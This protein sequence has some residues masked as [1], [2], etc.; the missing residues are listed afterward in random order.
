[1]GIAASVVWSLA[2]FPHLER[3][4]FAL[5]STD[6]VE[7]FGRAVALM[8]TQASVVLLLPTLLMGATFPFAIAAYQRW[9][10]SVG[11]GVGSLYAVNTLGNIAGSL[12]VGFVAIPLLG[13]RNSAVALVSVNLFVAAAL[14]AQTSPAGIRR[15]SWPVGAAVL[16]AAIHFGLS[17]QLFYRSLLRNDADEIVYYA[18]GASDTVAVVQHARSGERTLVYADGRGAAGTWTLRYNLYFGHLPMVLH[19][20]PRRVLHI[21]FGAG[22]S[23]KALSRHDVDQIDVVELSP[24]VTE[25][26]KYFWSNEGVL[27]DPRV[28]LVIEDGRNFLLRSDAMYDVV[29]LEPPKVQAAGVVN[30]YTQEF[31]ELVLAHLAPGGI[32]LQWLPTWTFSAADRGHLLR[33]FTEVFPH[34]SAWQQLR[35]GSLLLLGTREPLGVDLEAVEARLRDPA[36]QVDVEVMG[37]PTAAIFLSN[38]L[39]GDESLRERAAPF[40]PVRDDRTIVDYTIPHHVGAGFGLDYHYRGWSVGKLRNQLVREYESWQDPYS[41]LLADP[42]DASLVERA[43]IT[44][45]GTGGRKNAPLGGLRKRR[46]PIR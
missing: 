6:R 19:P 3:I 44:R 1:V 40:A 22:N 41:E 15:L 25:A 12:A 20:E 28:N 2:A 46:A 37:T 30:L 9:A 29:S 34:V 24:H 4:G 13:V 27:D 23:L 32:M 38:F 43:R 11:R 7:S 26:S 17:D 42:R 35:N 39:A 21:C 16:A 31:Y 18:E 8:F 14:L 36:L 10:S 33:A 45:L 5:T